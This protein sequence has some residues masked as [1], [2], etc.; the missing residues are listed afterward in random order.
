MIRHKHIQMA[1]AGVILL[2]AVAAP[3]IDVRDYETDSSCVQCLSTRTITTTR[4]LI[5]GVVYDET[6]IDNVQLTQCAKDFPL[7]QSEHEWVAIGCSKSKTVRWASPIYRSCGPQFKELPGLEPNWIVIYY[8]DDD[9]EFRAEARELL[10]SGQMSERELMNALRLMPGANDQRRPHYPDPTNPGGAAFLRFL[11][12]HDGG[13]HT[14]NRPQ[15]H[16]PES[17]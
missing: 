14:K 11:E 4:Y 7:H 5:F 6:S 3:F 13:I 9:S 2:F 10:K 15:L 12:K 17:D 1:L 8:N 16:T